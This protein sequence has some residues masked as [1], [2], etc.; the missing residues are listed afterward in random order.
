MFSRY[1]SAVLRAAGRSV[2]TASEAMRDYR[3]LLSLDLVTRLF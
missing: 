2:P 1:Y 3:A